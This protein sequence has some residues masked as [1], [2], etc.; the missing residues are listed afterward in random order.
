V[1]YDA[2]AGGAST[3]AWLLALVQLLYFTGT[4]FYVKSAIR[5][6]DNRRFLGLS[7]CY[8]LVAAAVLVPVSWW[9]T[10]LFGLLAARALVVPPRRPTPRSLGLGE[11]VATLCVALLS[12][13]V[14][15]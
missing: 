7:V 2:G 4:V 11:V 5:E 14:V 8:H 1:A 12:L 10:G 13:L 9:L 15:A 3:R 6:R